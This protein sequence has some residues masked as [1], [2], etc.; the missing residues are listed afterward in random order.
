MTE[1]VSADSDAQASSISGEWHKAW[2]FLEPAIRPGLMLLVFFASLWLLHHEFKSMRYE[3]VVASFRAISGKSIAAAIAF[4]AANFVVM[5]GY[6]WLGVR[7]V[8][9]R[10][11]SK[12]VVLASLLSYAFSNMLGVFLGGAPVRAR[13]YSSFGMPPSDIVRLVLVIGVAF[14]LGMFS[15]AGFL[16]VVAP[17]DIPERF[18]LPLA[19]SRPLGI[20]LLVVAAVFLLICG[21]RQRPLHVW[22]VNLQPPPLRIALAQMFVSYLDFMLASLVLY[23]LLPSDVAVGFFPFVAIFLL[24]VIVALVSHVPGGLG[25]LE[26]VLITMLPGSSHELVGALVAFRIIY[27]LLPLMI[28]VVVIAL[29]AL[30]QHQHVITGAVSA[31]VRWASVISPPVITGAVFVAGVVLLISGALPSTEGRLRLLHD[32]LPLTV[33]EVSHFLGSLIGAALIVLARGLQR[34]IDAAWWLTLALLATG[35]VVSLLKGLDYEEAILLTV[36]FVA[37]LPCKRYFF[38]HGRL[39]SP[40]WNAGWLS[41]IA[42]TVGIVA[43]LLLFS[44]RHVEYS[45]DLWWKF[46]YRGDAPRSM[47]DPSPPPPS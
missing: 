31:G 18:H 21:V 43:W 20:L 30:K 3:D 8:E 7:L 25:V 47:R 11:S 22:N 46:A 26:L 42:M 27:Y 1:T 45:H 36:L 35:A 32:W 15:L 5:I 33:V 23:V 38:R 12:Q 16:F 17:F 19:S 37:L 10:V 24:A 6:D 29:M 28:A 39:L 4:T 2:R 40:S 9:H 14:W 34:R 41:A 44:Y 13:L